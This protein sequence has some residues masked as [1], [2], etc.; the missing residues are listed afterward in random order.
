MGEQ[1]S[2]TLLPPIAIP[3]IVTLLYFLFMY[4]CV[5]VPDA[6][7]LLLL[8]RIHMLN[9]DFVRNRRVNNN[10]NCLKY[11]NEIVFSSQ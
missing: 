10:L 11:S 6:P 8:F 7:K 3:R 5:H 9:F 1:N 4:S 2:G